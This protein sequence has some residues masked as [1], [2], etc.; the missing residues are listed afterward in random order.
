MY[1]YIKSP[2]K[3][4]LRNHPSMTQTVRERT[5]RFFIDSNSHRFNTNSAPIQ[6]QFKQTNAHRFKQTN[7]ASDSTPI[8]TNTNRNLYWSS[9]W[10]KQT[11]IATITYLATE[12]PQT[13]KWPNAH[14]IEKPKNSKWNPNLN[15]PTNP[16]IFSLGIEQYSEEEKKKKKTPT[17]T[18]NNPANE[19]PQTQKQPNARSTKK[20]KNSKWNPNLNQPTNPR[21]FSLGIDQ[22]SEEGKKGR[23]KESDW[24]AW[25]MKLL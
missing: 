21:I 12:K 6:H 4:E 24:A 1:L 25:A 3:L 14:S 13:Q 16:W 11:P 23:G 17:T 22:Y 10:F 18:I 2:I 5:H 15:Q 20:P 9:H 19:K 7:I 8:Q